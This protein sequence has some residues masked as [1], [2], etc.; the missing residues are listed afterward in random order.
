MEDLRLLISDDNKLIEHFDNLEEPERLEL[1]LKI[2]NKFC[3]NN[4][5]RAKPYT[6]TD[7]PTGVYIRHLNSETH[8]FNVKTKFKALFKE[9]IAQKDC[10][11]Q[12]VGNS[13]HYMYEEFGFSPQYYNH[14]NQGQ[15]AGNVKSFR[16]A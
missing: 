3:R 8:I 13:E 5:R 16:N 2:C 1:L 9:W 7:V 6:V 12:N 11:H 4:T 15:D 10:T 14:S